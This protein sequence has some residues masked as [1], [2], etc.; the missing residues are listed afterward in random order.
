MK[1]LPNILT[2][3]RLAC[4]PVLVFVSWR[5]FSNLFL[6]LLVF[7]FVTDVLD[8]Y[9]ARKYQLQTRLGA[10]LDSL[11]DFAVY[12]VIPICA[13]LLWPVVIRQEIVYVIAIIASIVLPVM[14]GIV[15]FGSFTSYH[16]WLTKV[17]AA[18]MATSSILL[19]LGGPVWLFRAAAILCVC[20]ALEEICITMLLSE[21]RT[22]V[23]TLWHVIRQ[24]HRRV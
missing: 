13:W 9:I 15:K 6:G 20:A 2:L 14:S 12:M 18:S 17:A 22:N 8:G 19:F 4:V 5:G 3:I 24:R 21:P 23:R 10:K 11:A 1:N 16:T 7:A